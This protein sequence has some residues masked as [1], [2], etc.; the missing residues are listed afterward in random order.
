MV[1]G[2]RVPTDDMTFVLR[3]V[4]PG[5]GDAAWPVDAD[6]LEEILGQA[7][8]F[9]VER[10][11]PLSQAG[12]REGTRHA[13]GQVRTPAGFAGAYR[14][15]AAGGWIGVNTPQQWGGSALPAMMT[16]P[17]DEVWNSANMAF[18][19]C[20]ILTQAAIKLLLAA[21]TE[22]QKAE[23]IPALASGRWTAA[24]GLTEPGAGSDL[25]LVTSEALAVGDGS[26]RIVGE[27]IFTSYG[28]HEWSEN[29]LNLVLARIRGAGSLSLFVVPRFLRS[30]AANDVVC[31]GVEHKLGLR[32]SPTCTMRYGGAGGATGYLLGKENAGLA[33]MFVMMN[34]ARIACSLQAVGL[35]ERALQQ[36]RTYAA[37]R[38]QGRDR[39][40]ATV[41][42]QEH[43]DVQRM[44]LRMAGLTLASR[45]LAYATV[46][47]IAAETDRT[48]VSA[49]ALLTPLAKV[50]TSEAACE[51]A[52]LNIQ[53]HGGIGYVEESGA[54]QLLRDAC[55][56]PIYEGTNGI[57]AIDFLN[58]KVLADKGETLAEM[59]AMA[60]RTASRLARLERLEGLSHR[61]DEGADALEAAAG[62]LLQA[63][64]PAGAR[65]A[66]AT[67]F[68]RLAGTLVAG[69]LLGRG[70]AHA[71]ETGDPAGSAQIPAAVH[72]GH[73]ILTQ[74]H[75]HAA[76]VTSAAGLVT[77]HG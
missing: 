58:R 7:G 52:H 17:L 21:G 49:G 32:A 11:L 72:Y 46:A 76:E 47:E 31:T 73:A 75:G 27:K 26:Y 77:S 34:E 36:S 4:L 45:A 23:Y 54:G 20:P 48:S 50:F 55:A 24:M 39:H 3:H 63:D 56:I 30:G 25:A 57:Q 69:A 59:S 10:L 38:R 42:L 29:I 33:A 35:C 16:A 14:D 64:R 37:A 51:V 71:A 62:W 44:L 66:A 43:P 2:Y 19:L 28:E 9:A 6:L 13:D 12:D 68:T 1:A 61:I 60:R 67:P 70:I 5:E 74:C 53:V 65:L 40:G 8:R 22:A 41:A 15:W 18:Y